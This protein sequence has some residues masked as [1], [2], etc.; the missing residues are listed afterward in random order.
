MVLGNPR[1]VPPNQI[2][3]KG[4]NQTNITI[5]SSTLLGGV[6]KDGTDAWFFYTLF[7]AVWHG[8]KFQ[9]EFPAEK[10]YRH[11]L[12][13]EVD[14]FQGVVDRVKEKIKKKEIQQLDPALTILVKLSDEGLLEPYILIS[15]ADKGISQDYP[16]YRDA[17]REKVR[18]Y[19]A[20][21]IIHLAQ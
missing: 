9:K 17:H 10:E 2:E 6:K 13:E 3:D 20:E 7:R 15:R 19:I 18:Q 5:D 4:K 16:A 1:I 8:E 14:G 21:W 11:S 12:P